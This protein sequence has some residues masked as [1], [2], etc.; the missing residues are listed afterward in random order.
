MF[1]PFDIRWAYASQVPGLWNRS[2]PDLLHILPDA[3]GFFA[4]RLQAVAEPE[5]HPTCYAQSLCDQHEL[6]K[7]VFLIPYFENLSGAPR[8]NLSESTSRYLL[9]LGLE[10][11]QATT[12][13]VW[14]HALA[15]TYSPAYL[16][17]NAAGIRQ[18]WPRIPLPNAAD[19][20]RASAALGKQVAALLDPDTPVPGVTTGTIR[21]E[22]ASIAVPTTVL[23]APRDWKL[24]GWGSRSDKGI[25][26]P[27]RGH[28][29]ARDYSAAEAAT[30][31]HAA[32][33]GDKTRDVRM[34]GASFWRNVPE[35][36]WDLH[37]GGYQVIKK[38]LSYRDNSILDRALTEA[39][40]E[41]IQATARRL[42]ALLAARPG[43]R[44]EP[45]RLRRRPCAAA[46][47]LGS[48][49][50]R[51]AVRAAEFG[52]PHSRSTRMARTGGQTR[53]RPPD[54]HFQGRQFVL[55]RVPVDWNAG[56]VVA[57]TQAIAHAAD[58]TP[59]L[60]RYQ[61]ELAVA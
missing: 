56:P 39:E 37:I 29:D 32:L 2:R 8:P 43:T 17:E 35:A 52:N 28:T 51:A 36:V 18:G 20:L 60:I 41:H 61:H 3:A 21:P 42:A 16:T 33:L 24:I 12:H 49:R 22:L 27:G 30:A 38:W 55:D 19:L 53:Q 26:M 1:R 10:V 23:G 11:D 47:G 58:V 4:T 15:T 7:D 25:T 46:E 45:P 57:V 6:H 14:D 31:A 5:G 48:T 13:L 40:V 34:N 59:W 54:V 50:Q 9:S 44:H